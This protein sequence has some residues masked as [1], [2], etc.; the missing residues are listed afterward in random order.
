MEDYISFETAKLLKEKGF[1]QWCSR[2]YGVDVR[3]KGKSI[4]FDEECDLKDE[5]LGNEI[6]YIDGGRLYD[7]GCNNSDED[8]TG[9]AAPTLWAAMKWLREVHKLYIVVRPYVTEEG[10][11]SLFDVK[12][13]KE[14][15]IIVNI[16]TKTGFTTYEEACEEAIRYCLE[17]LV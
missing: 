11:F 13:I 4:S 17:N 7:C 5:G 2:C 6:E 8:S 10:F 3:Y 9:W 12:S 1:K 15:E 16:R 14:K